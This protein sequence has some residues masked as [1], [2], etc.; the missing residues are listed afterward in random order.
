MNKRIFRLALAISIIDMNGL[1]IFDYLHI[2]FVPL[3]FS[4][5]IDYTETYSIIHIRPNVAFSWLVVFIGVPH[6]ENTLRITFFMQTL[7]YCQTIELIVD[8]SLI[9]LE[10][11]IKI[12]FHAIS[13]HDFITAAAV[14]AS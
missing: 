8:S 6:G 5:E 2:A 12:L 14:I 13:S 9:C 11:G 4:N 1:L 3:V 7:L 10:K